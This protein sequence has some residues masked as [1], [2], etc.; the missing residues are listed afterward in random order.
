MACVI[1]PKNQY[2][3]FGCLVTSSHLLFPDEFGFWVL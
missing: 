1:N 2:D 3:A